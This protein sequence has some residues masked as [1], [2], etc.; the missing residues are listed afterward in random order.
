MN[1]LLPIETINRELD[2]KIVLASLLADKK[3]KIYIGQHD[4]LMSL[5][6]KMQGGIYIGKNIFH[7]RAELE[8]GEIY[9]RLKDNKIDVIYIHE[10]GAVFPGQE[11]DWKRIIQEQYSLKYFDKN[12][13]VLQWGDFQKEFDEMR[14][15]SLKMVTTGHPRFDLYKPKWNLL[16]K[17]EI[18]KIKSEFNDFILINGNYLANHGLGEKYLFSNNGGYKVEDIN[19][20][21]KRVKYYT[22]N[23][24]QLV[25]MVELTHELAVK[26]PELNFVYR[27]HPSENHEYYKQVFK[28][29]SNIIVKHQGAVTPWILASMAII[30]DGCTTALEATL[31]SK[32]VINY[33]IELKEEFDIWLPNQMGVRA[34]TIDQVFKYI[35]DIREGKLVNN[36]DSVADVVKNLMFNFENDSYDAF[37]KEVK[38]EIAK[39]ELTKQISPSAFYIWKTFFSRKIKFFLYTIFKVSKRKEIEYHKIKFYGFDKRKVEEK[40]NLVSKIIHKKVEVKIHNPYLIQ[41]ENE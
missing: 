39:K 21:M 26:F 1:I 10:E 19:S 34:V 24:K 4:F 20:R 12:D 2:F 22:Y 11:E 15:N 36:P 28:G 40:F 16:F 27:P 8:N 5:L 3:N 31:A 23:S 41:I 13:L 25:S 6:P 29:V 9:K 37:V 17:E 38:I 35:D 30:H 33:K 14:N 7:K 18:D 32:P